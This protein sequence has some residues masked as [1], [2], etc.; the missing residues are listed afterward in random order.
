MLSTAQAARILGVNESR[1]R[2]L[3]NAKRLKAEKVSGVWVIQERAL[4]KVKVRK[5]GWPKGKKRA[6]K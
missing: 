5:P 1:V 3:I 2:A 4:K 6:K